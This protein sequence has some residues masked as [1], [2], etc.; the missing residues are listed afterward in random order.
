MRQNL[1]EGPQV[2]GY[3]SY[4]PMLLRYL[5]DQ[6]NKDKSEHGHLLVLS[7]Q[8][9]QKEVARWI[10]DVQNLQKIEYKYHLALRS[11]F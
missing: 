9:W 1:K 6:G 2:N 7:K 4:C 11:S 3:T 8:G 10:G 5:D